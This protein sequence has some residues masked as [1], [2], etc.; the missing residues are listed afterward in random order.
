MSALLS[1]GFSA[2][3]NASN[4]GNV[5]VLQA[6]VAVEGFIEDSLCADGTNALSIAIGH[7]HKE[8]IDL[9]TK[10]T[11][12][13]KQPSSVLANI[14]GECCGSPPAPLLPMNNVTKLKPWQVNHSL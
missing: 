7:D 6:I 11:T 10:T 8:V 9:L 12:A 14:E 5:H 2:L 1:V 13:I 4:N 3:W